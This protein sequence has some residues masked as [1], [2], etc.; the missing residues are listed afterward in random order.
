MALI[1]RARYQDGV[2]LTLGPEGDWCVVTDAFHPN[3]AD[4]VSYPSY[5]AAY[6]AWIDALEILRFFG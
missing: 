1:T 3:G 2:A 5:R 6:S 4:S